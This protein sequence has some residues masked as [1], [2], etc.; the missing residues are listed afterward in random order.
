[1]ERLPTLLM[2]FYEL[3]FVLLCLHVFLRLR[4]GRSLETAIKLTPWAAAFGATA[5]LVFIR[6]TAQRAEAESSVESSAAG[7]PRPTTLAA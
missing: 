4:A 1:M 3:L 2:H 6:L 5:S 7:E